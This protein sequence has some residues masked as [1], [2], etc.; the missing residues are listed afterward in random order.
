[1][2]NL[3]LSLWAITALLIASAA[4]AAPRFRTELPVK[5]AGLREIVGTKP[6]GGLRAFHL[7]ANQRFDAEDYTSFT[8]VEDTGIRCIMAPCPSSVDTKFVVTNVEE[9]GRETVKYT[10]VE[11]LKNIPA[12]VRIAPRWLFVT[13][14]SMELV[15]PGGGGFMRR[16]VWNV[17]VKPF[18]TGSR[19]YYGNPVAIDNRARD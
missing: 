8:L 9:T 12:N 13:E 6:V 19:Y 7:T 14:S 1:M 11:V 2:K 15:A 3:S 5:Q 17:Q 16:E 18:A 10:A 4:N